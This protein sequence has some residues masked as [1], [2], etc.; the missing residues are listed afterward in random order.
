M[1]P[2]VALA[3]LSLAAWLYLVFAHGRFWQAD[4]RVDGRAPDPERWPS[5]VVVM[6]ARNEADVVARAVTSLL[7]QDYPG[8]FRVVLADQES[9][10][11]TAEVARVAAKE[12]DRGHRLV[13]E[14]TGERPPGWAGKP[15]AL[16]TGLGRAEVEAPFA[17]FWLFT[18]ADVAHSP[19]NLR[20]LVAKT[21]AERLDLVSLMVRL[22][23]EVGIA[24]LLVPAYVY[25]FQKLFPFPRI[26]D[27]RSDMAAAAGGCVLVR[28]EALDRAG[29]LEP[30]RGESIDDCALAS[31][32]KRHGRVW[33]GLTDSERSLRCY[34]GV[35]GVWEMVARRAFT[36]L[37]HSWPLLAGTL[38]GLLLLYAAPP[39]LAV[40]GG[41][42]AAGL[43]AGAW[44]LMAASF[45]PTLTLYGGPAWWGFALPIAGILYAGMTLDSALR[46]ARSPGRSGR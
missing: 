29:G 24:R 12:H 22:R 2:D 28:R 10:D 26:N 42:L 18:D 23:A 27:P 7:D 11:G 5:V 46:H 44:C 43:A 35:R 16:Q 15:W 3:T 38:A 33:V 21:A 37:G 20:R 17:E 9:D 41:G 34:Q 45:L 36:R 25:F 8:P 4:Q 32:L 1:S 14:R 39:L 40:L 13:I 31:A 30:L 6:P 19:G